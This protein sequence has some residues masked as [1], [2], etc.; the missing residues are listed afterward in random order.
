MREADLALYR[1]KGAG[2]EGFVVF[3]ESLR[4]EALGRAGRE[5]IIRSAL[6]DGRFI[7][8]LQP[9]VALLDNE[10][11]GH[12][13]T[14]RLPQN[15]ATDV[16]PFGLEEIADDST[17]VTEVDKLT[18]RT[19]AQLLTGEFGF[20]GNVSIKVS[21]RT[22]HQPGFA[23]IMANV[24]LEAG[25]GCYRVAVELTEQILVDDE[26]VATAAIDRLHAAGFRVGLSRFGRDGFPLAKL[27]RLKLDFVK[28]D[29]SFIADLG[30][31][32]EAARSVLRVLFEIGTAFDFDVI[33]EGIDTPVQAQKLLEL[34]CRSG[35]GELLG[36]PRN[37][38]EFVTMGLPAADVIG[39]TDLTPAPVTI[40]ERRGSG[41]GRGRR[42]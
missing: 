30:A 21:A 10:T 25:A 32:E 3:D 16:L 7:P 23:D 5:G 40:I 19:A 27:R 1:A 24:V 22:I 15:D 8:Y 18:L 4:L 6:D 34:G 37:V 28:I 14:L 35:Q 31:D 17:L 12:E 33:A 29:R 26:Q 42:N 9:I 11:L 13:I 41:S 2:R 38:S 36:R 20:A 39:G